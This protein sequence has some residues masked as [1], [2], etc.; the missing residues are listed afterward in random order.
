MASLVSLIFLYCSPAS[1]VRLQQGTVQF[2]I[3]PATLQISVDSAVVNL[4]QI[5]QK[6]SEL[7][8]SSASANWHWPKRSIQITARLEGNDL[9]LNFTSKH[10]QILNWFTL[11]SQASA[12]LLPLGEGS[13]IPL[14]NTVWQSYLVKEQTPLDTNFDLKLPLWSQEQKGKIYSWLLLTP[15][16]NEVS[17]SKTNTHLQM[18]SIHKFNRFNQQ[19]P[20]EVLLHVGN[21]PLSG[22]IRYREYLQQSGQFSSLRDKIK[23]APEGKKL[24][25]ATHIYLWGS[26]LLA[27]ED[28]KN[29]VGLVS[30]L[31]TSEGAALW[32][33][34]GTEANKVIQ[35]LQG[36]EPEGWQ[37][38]SLIEAINNALVALVPLNASPDQD[39]FLLAQQ[40]RAV[41]V[42]QLAQHQLGA[43]LAPPDSWGPGLSKQ[44]IELLHQAGLPQLWLGTDNWTAEFLHPEAVANAKKSGY[45]IASYDSYDTGIPP[46][47]NDSWLT[48]QLP[49]KLREKCAIVRADGSKKPGFRGEGYYLNPA[50]MLPYSQQRMRELTQLAGLNSLFLDVDGTGMVS[51]DYQP[52]HPT[53]AAQMADARNARMAWYSNT[54]KLPLGSED[55][56]A[57]TARH[58]M[59]AHGMETWGFGWGDKDMHQDKKSP[60]YLGAWWPNA[61][62]A[63]FFRPA[64]VKQPY[65]TVEFD[66]RYRLPLYQAVFHDAVISSHHWTYDNLKFSDVKTT[67]ELLS[68]LYNTPPLFN[69]NRSTL[70]ARLPEIIKA[71]AKFR[72]LHQALWDKALIDFRWLDQ[73]GF[74]QQTTFSDGSVLTANFGDRTFNGIA[75]K[76]L[77]ANLPN[78]RILD[79]TK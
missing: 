28:V 12:L 65:L 71:D 17:F 74:V 48:A 21:T 19:Q 36:R 51:D 35:Q 77:R 41:K 29:W 6:V 53:G 2:D 14:D 40:Q 34:M 57:V 78:G 58:I 67:R 75:A 66:P 43:Y 54:L 13:R 52:E 9:R 1:A 55:G 24:V 5:P 72:P 62:P 37:K 15:F 60:Y 56:N 38:Q 68:Q 63:T 46:G 79:F 4:P 73:K 23:I 7:K 32:Q 16:S 25:G 70:K 45:L 44:V 50:C 31:Q 11:P 27:Q 3:D 76:S 22:A 8:Y 39:T 33:N 61:Q 18:Q 47:I 69:L 20:F 42:R 59:F 49:G 10:P 30:Y 26:M 64:K